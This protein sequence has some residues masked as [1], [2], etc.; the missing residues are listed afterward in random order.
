MKASVGT[1]IV[2]LVTLAA[3]CAR[4]GSG[5]GGDDQQFSPTG[6]APLEACIQT[7]CPAGWGSCG[8]G[9]CTTDTTKDLAN[10]G[11]CGQAC[12]QPQTSFH[13]TSICNRGH[14]AF[15]CNNLYGD[16]NFDMGDGCE[17]SLADD[18]KHCGAC[19]HK[20]QDGEICWRGACGC[21]AGFSTCGGEC[22]NLAKDNGSC[23][24]C[25]T[26]C[27]ALPT[28]DPAWICG[29][30]VQPPQTTWGCDG[31]CKLTCENKWADCDHDFCGNGC[32]AFIDSDPKN[33]GACGR[34]CNANQQCVNGECL[35]PGN[36]TRC[37]SR[38]VDTSVDI[39]NCGGCGN[40]CDGASDESAHGAP[41][42]AGGKCGYVCYAGFADCNKNLYD[43]C[44]VDLRSDQQ[45]CGSCGTSCDVARGQPCVL[46]KCLTKPCD[47]SE[48]PK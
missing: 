35:C 18:P 12:P 36:L 33:C 45:H 14:C 3:A 20:C 21:P 25:D 10:C 6:A 17:T 44:E 31:G 11:G 30:G 19:D 39:D 28:N 47:P 42:C 7:E 37:G 26:S 27:Q 5:D 23:G 16:C 38:C 1:A 9:P 8:T 22:K 48:V 24:A 34:A 15:A 40:S 43:G 41:T 46:G 2:L 13:V 29:P 32:E 4:S